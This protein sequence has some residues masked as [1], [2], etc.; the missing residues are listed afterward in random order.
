MLAGIEEFSYFKWVVIPILIFLSRI[1]DVSIGTTR[2][3]FVSRGYKKLAAFTGFFEVLVWLLA[4][5][6]IMQNLS[7]PMCYIA[8]ASGF[9]A[10]NYIGIA[11]AEKLSLGNVL[12]EVITHKD[13]TVLVDSLKARKYGITSIEGQGAMGPV[14]IIKTIAPRQEVDDIIYLIKEYNPQAFYVVQE[15]GSVSEGRYS[16]R[17]KLGG[18]GINRLFRPHRKGK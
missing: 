5:G 11:L 17:R 16:V 15:V 8:Y 18:V 2:V 1:V 9:A 3:I 12:I 7:N 6:Q 4:I 13:S 14:S 10:G